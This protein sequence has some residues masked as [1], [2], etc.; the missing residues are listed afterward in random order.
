MK[1][2]VTVAAAMLAS[3]LP[4]LAAGIVVPAE[5]RY[6][7]YS[8][9]IEQCDD[10]VALA[11]I[12]YYFADKEAEFWHSSL[13]ILGFDNIKEIGYRS[14]GV[15]FIPRRYCVAQAHLNDQTTHAIVYQIQ[16]HMGF[17]GYSD[18]EEWCVVGLDRNLAYAPACAILKPLY[19]RYAHDKF[20]IPA[21]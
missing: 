16:E 11:Y 20:E 2:F 19:V 4:A 3:S 8:G 17:A 9:D 1:R 5:E 12:K 18:N 10:S 14:N 7:P 13:E 21:K 6:V 15:Q